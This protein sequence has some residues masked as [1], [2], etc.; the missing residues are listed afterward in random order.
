MTTRERKEARIERRREWAAKREEKAE[1]AMGRYHAIADG[2]PLGQPILVG[3]H[4]ERHARRDVA[5][6]DSAVGAAIDHDKMARHHEEVAQGIEAQLDRS[7]YSDDPD[8]VDML[9]ERVEA[10][11]CKRERIK[12]YNASCRKGQP[13]VGLLA[14][15]EKSDLD[16]CLRIGSVFVGPKGQFPA[17]VLANLSGNITRNRKRLAELE[18]REVQRERVRQAMRAEEA[19]N[20]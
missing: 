6:M 8:A 16:A 9:R 4:S 12:A 10:L 5:R 14:P 11:E 15:A 18:D 3:H 2:I 19:G 13:N 20:G 7:I 17:Y 1:A